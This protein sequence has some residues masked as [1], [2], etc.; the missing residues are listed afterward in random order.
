MAATV[1]SP[2]AC[3]RAGAIRVE[4]SSARRAR[5]AARRRGAGGGALERRG[6]RRRSARSD[7][8]DLVIDA[9]LR[10]RPV[11]P[12][13]RARG[14]VRRSASTL[15]PRAGGKVLGVDVPSGLDG[16]TGA[17]RGAAV[18]ASATRHVLPAA[19]P[20]ICCCRRRHAGGRLVFAD[21]GIRAE[22]ARAIA[23]Q[24]LRQRASDLAR[25]CC[26]ARRRIA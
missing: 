14:A 2:R 24:R 10:R 9:L 22:R 12:R 7:G 1:S 19:S 17:V 26:R 21:I 25:R 13:R 8:A 6:P 11:A 3:W 23:P 15:S 5:R 18:A 20:A 4:V 16:E